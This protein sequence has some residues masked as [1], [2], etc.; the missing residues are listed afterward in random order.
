MEY[1]IQNTLRTIYT[2]DIMA[3]TTFIGLK[4]LS[5]YEGIKYGNAN[6]LDHWSLFRHRFLMILRRMILDLDLL[7]LQLIITDHVHMNDACI[8]VLRPEWMQ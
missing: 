5:I 4:T 6:Q 3:D 8:S 2:A 7:F 1:F